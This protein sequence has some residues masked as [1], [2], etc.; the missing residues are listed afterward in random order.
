MSYKWI[1]RLLIVL[2]VVSLGVIIKSGA[3]IVELSAFFTSLIASLWLLNQQRNRA[4]N[5]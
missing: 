5:K 4:L 3:E 2:N 1:I